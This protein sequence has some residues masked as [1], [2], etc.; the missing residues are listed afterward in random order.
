MFSTFFNN[1]FALE[2]IRAHLARLNVSGLVYAY[3]IV[4]KIYQEDVVV[5]SNRQEWFDFYLENNYQLT[6]PVVIR[7][8]KE[9]GDF[10]WAKDSA[11][12]TA[13]NLHKVI[14]AAEKESIEVGH[15]FILHDPMNNVVILS[16]I[17]SG[18]SYGRLHRYIETESDNLRRLLVSTHL[19]ALSLYDRFSKPEPRDQSAPLS[20]RENEVLYLTSTGKKYYETAAR[21]GISVNTVKYHIGNAIRK[22]GARNAL[23]AV[24]RAGEM[25][26]FEHGLT[27]VKPHANNAR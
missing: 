2:I 25:R 14:S 16:L 22:L 17:T 9:I 23:D 24:G 8:M 27:G 13:T 7:A 20:K 12:V 10:S 5:V 19:E 26:L 3:M 11:E 4:N 18:D 21:L 15:T 6:D 1:H